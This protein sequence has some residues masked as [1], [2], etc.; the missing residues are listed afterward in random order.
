MVTVER[1]PNSHKALGDWQGYSGGG[2]VVMTHSS[3]MEASPFVDNSTVVSVL[4]VVAY[5]GRS[6]KNVNSG[7]QYTF[8][9][10]LPV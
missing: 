7:Q 8:G 10:R 5:P 3:Q 4:H 6:D 1:F 2:T 9:P